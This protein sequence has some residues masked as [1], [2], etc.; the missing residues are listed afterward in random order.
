M[1]RSGKTRSSSDPA[2]DLGWVGKPPWKALV[3][4]EGWLGG[5][6]AAAAP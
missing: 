6:W 3:V 2:A 4:R 1:P 5:L